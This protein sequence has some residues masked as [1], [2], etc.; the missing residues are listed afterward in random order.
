M[1]RPSSQC[2]RRRRKAGAEPLARFERGVVDGAV[3]LL[4]DKVEDVAAVLAFREAVP[5]IFLGIDAELRRVGAVVDRAGTAQTGA[6]AFEGVEHAIVFQHLFHRE[7]GADGPEINERFSFFGHEMFSF[8]GSRA[9]RESSRVQLG[10]IAS[11]GEC[12]LWITPCREQKL[13]IYCLSLMAAE[14]G[15]HRLARSPILDF[16]FTRHRV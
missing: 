5:D 7:P 6:A 8:H 15:R 9:V 12:Q 13:T 11:H 10:M 1:C 16:P 3:L 4:G 14:A 2:E